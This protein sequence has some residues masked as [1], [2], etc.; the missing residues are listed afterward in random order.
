VLPNAAAARTGAVNVAAGASVVI[1]TKDIK[2]GDKLDAS[3]LT[4]A[5]VPVQ[6]VPQGAFTTIPQVLS[7]DHGGAPVALQPIAAHEALLPAKLSGPG[8]R[9]SVAAEIAEGMRA[10]TI[11][12][13]DVTGAGGHALPGDHVDVVLMR[14]VTPTGPSRTYVSD[15]VIQNTR[16]LGI[17]LNAD[18]SANKPADPKNATLEVNVE[19]AQKLA[20]ASTLGTLSLALRRTGEANPELVHTMATRAFLAGGGPGPSLGAPSAVRV[21]SRSLGGALRTG[22]P[23]LITVVEYGGRVNRPAL[24][25]PSPTP[26]AAPVAP[27]LSDAAPK[28]GA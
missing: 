13:S 27:Q 25:A 5:R 10:Y 17:D 11:K 19:D 1:A 18:L 21:R 9:P 26:A 8:A 4:I 23:G 14:D 22:G 16:V 12:V 6:V 3:M 15:V 7:Q 2:Y 28:T 20:I 24:A